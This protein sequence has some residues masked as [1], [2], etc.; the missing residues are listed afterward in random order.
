[1]EG[2]DRLV[3]EDQPT[4]RPADESDRY[5]RGRATCSQMIGRCSYFMGGGTE[6]AG[7]IERAI[8]DY[9]EL[10]RPAPR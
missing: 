1:M 8:A 10:T 5:L 7:W 4:C 9:E 2:Y 6:A 3:R